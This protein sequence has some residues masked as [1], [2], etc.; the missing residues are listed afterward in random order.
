MP[1]LVYY[2]NMFYGSASAA[3]VVD[4][5]TIEVSASAKMNTRLGADIQGGDIEPYLKMT[6]ALKQT[7]AVDAGG[8][9]IEALP[10]MKLTAAC[11]VSI[12]AVP[13]A[14]DIAQAIWQSSSSRYNVSGSMGEKLNNASSAGNPWSANPDDNNGTGTMG[15]AVNE[16][17]KKTNLIPGLF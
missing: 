13:S 3:M 5:P 8:E 7:L 1:L 16:I 11:S 15:A 12:G 9:M 2:N 4:D 10:K 6:R 14:F 17:K